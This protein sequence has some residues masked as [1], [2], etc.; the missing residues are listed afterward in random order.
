MCSYCESRCKT[1]IALQIGSI[2]VDNMI[3]PSDAHDLSERFCR[4]IEPSSACYVWNIFVCKIPSK[5]RNNRKAGLVKGRPSM[6]MTLDCPAWTK[7]AWALCCST[8]SCV[9]ILCICSLALMS[10]SQRLQCT[11]TGTPD[12]N[13]QNNLIN[14]GVY[15]TSLMQ[16]NLQMYMPHTQIHIIIREWYLRMYTL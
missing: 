7:S 4:I 5:T 8:A 13:W 1:P 2:R 16:S 12:A 14:N 6:T 3:I 10:C 11:H 15:C 9:Q